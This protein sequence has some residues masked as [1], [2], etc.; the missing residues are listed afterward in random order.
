M[1]RAG[2]LT[3]IALEAS[4]EEV[5]HL[6]DYVRRGKGTGR[7]AV[8]SL[9]YWPWRTE[10]FL[11]FV[12]SV[13]RLNDGLP[14]DEKVEF[15]GVDYA[16]PGPT[17]DFVRR[18]FAG[19]NS[20]RPDTLAGLEPLRRIV[21]WSE[22]AKLSLGERDELLR[23]LKELRR[24]AESQPVVPVSLIQGLRI[25]ELS[26]E[27][28]D[29][30]EDIRDRVMADAVLGLLSRSDKERHV[31]IWAH[32]LHLA[33]GPI[34][35]AVPMGYYLK[36]R[37]AEKYRAIGSM[38]YAGSFRT[39]SGLQGKMVTHVVELPPP[40]YFESVMKRVSPSGGMWS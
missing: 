30:D 40:F 32:E 25:T 3:T 13:R 17:V 6:D 4:W 5:A 38:F 12:E 24:V 11:A 37:L 16:P 39:Y 35:G 1:I 7:D 14:F 22:M 34:E 28:R 8:R 10:E 15:Q 29:P 33:E 36:T 27:S 19:E 9:A 26:A 2:W 31:A 23:V 20:V 18:Y 21:N